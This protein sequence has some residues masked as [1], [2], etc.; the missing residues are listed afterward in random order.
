MKYS[1]YIKDFQYIGNGKGINT[2]PN[3][4]DLSELL[5][6]IAVEFEHTDDINMSTSIA[7]DHLSE[8]DKYYTILI[9]SGLVDENKSIQLA[10]KFLQDVNIMYNNGEEKS[11]IEKDDS[12]LYPDSRKEMNDMNDMILSPNSP[13]YLNND[14]DTTDELLGY[15]PHNVG[16]YTNEVDIVSSNELDNG[17]RYQNTNDNKT[18][19]VQG[20]ENNNKEV[21]LQGNDGTEKVVSIDNMD[22]LKKLSE[23]EIKN[24][25]LITEEQIKLARQALNNRGIINNMTKQEAVRLLIKHNI[26]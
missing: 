26:K 9:N 12:K 7:L 14:D 5:V 25:D 3:D 16:D 18:Y 21:K 11:Q 4:V 10:L 17:D 6:G 1:D 8:N 24:N 2:S 23:T 13:Q 22:L 15:K 20:T 19:T